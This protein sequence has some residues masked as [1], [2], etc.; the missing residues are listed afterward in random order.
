MTQDNPQQTN[1]TGGGGKPTAPHHDLVEAIKSLGEKNKAAQQ[2]QAEHDDKA[3]FWA[4]S[5]GAG[6][7]IYTA[8]TLGIAIIALCQLNTARDTEDRQLRAYIGIVIPSDGPGDRNFLPPNI[9]AI[10]LSIK[11]F[12]QTPAYRVTYQSGVDLKQYPLP[13][14]TEYPTPTIGPQNPITVFP[15]TP[16]PLGIRSPGGRALTNE[17]VKAIQDGNSKRLCFWGTITYVDAFGYSRY[18]NYCFSFFN[19]TQNAMPYEPCNDHND[20]N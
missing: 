13:K 11:N 17:E 16:E 3:L 20:S 12:G 19:L 18:T 1:E 15:G 7:G 8:I 9:P 6:V 2:K 4:R 5:A 14:N 10:H